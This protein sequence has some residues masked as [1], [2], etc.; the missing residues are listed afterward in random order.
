MR[1]VFKALL[2]FICSF[3]FETNV[4]A[5]ENV[6]CPLNKVWN[7]AV[8]Q[9]GPYTDFR[10]V[11]RQTVLALK[12]K[13]YIQKDI[14]VTSETIFDD[15]LEWADICISSKQS[16]IRFLKDSLYDGKLDA[17]KHEQNV[18]SLKDRIENK[19]DIDM[20]FA[21][22]TAAGLSASKEKFNVPTLVMTSSDPESAGI[23]GP[24]EFSN[25]ENLHVQKEVDRD[26]S[27]LTMF[28]KIFNFK[29]LGTLVDIRENIQLSQS[30]PVM[31][32]M[33]KEYGFDLVV[34]KKD[35]NGP[36]RAL[37][38]A[39]Y[40]ACIK[41]LSLTSDAV[42][43]TVGN[44]IDPNNHYLQLKPL[45]DKKIPTF[46]QVGSKDVEQGVLLA[47]SET[48]LVESGMFEAEVIEKIIKG[49]SID[50]IS[51]YYYSPLLLSLNMYVARL[52]NW[53]P[54]FEMLIAVD[55]VYETIE[56]N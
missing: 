9:A 20:V 29:R 11:F 30:L 43:L 19:G 56:G 37:N 8:L 44:G 55:K 48:D 24:G 47:M 51:Q 27:G 26:R 18:E 2:L 12:D 10:K 23:I 50:T 15:P 31:K 13:G 3:A 36:D 5:Q 32:Q 17:H 46:S 21:M 35:I 4:Y 33:S 40:S 49:Q 16:C 38:Y 45:I 41:E 39:N 7:V 53:K 14:K 28:Y 42:F 52:I 1:L 6:N 54:P 22:G 25:I 34:C